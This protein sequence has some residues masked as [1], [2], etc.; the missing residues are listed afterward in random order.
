VQRQ[1]CGSV[2]K[3]GNGI[4]TVHLGYAAGEFHCLLDGDPY[5][6]KSWDAL[7]CRCR[8]A[9]IPDEVVYRPKT[10]IALELYDRAVA[11]GVRLEWLTFDEGYGGKPEFLRGLESREQKFVAEIT[12]NFMAWIEPGQVTTRPFRCKG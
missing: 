7:R 12:R 1:Y 4:V 8:E 2:G 10:H 6:P 11:N 3:G 5:L 9:G